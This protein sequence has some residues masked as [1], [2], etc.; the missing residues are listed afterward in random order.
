MAVYGHYKSLFN[1]YLRSHP[2]GQKEKVASPQYDGN[3]DN[4]QWQQWYTSGA[5]LREIEFWIGRQKPA[6][7][8]AAAVGAGGDD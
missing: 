8:L 4:D 2:G 5:N 1:E 3:L 6:M 7:P